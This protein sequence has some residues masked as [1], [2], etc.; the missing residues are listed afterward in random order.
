MSVLL[1]VHRKR[2][3]FS[4]SLYLPSQQGST[5][6]SLILL[7]ILSVSFLHSAV[8]SCPSYL[9]GKREEHRIKKTDFYNYTFIVELKESQFRYFILNNVFFSQKKVLKVF[10]LVLQ[11]HRDAHFKFMDETNV[12]YLCLFKCQFVNLLVYY[13]L[14]SI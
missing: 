14:W 12:F 5:P 7:S 4:L 2:D 8:T 11:L 3:D 13:C 9:A 10:F 6:L 1:Y